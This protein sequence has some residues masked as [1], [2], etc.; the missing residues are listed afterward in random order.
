MKRVFSIDPGSNTGFV[1]VDFESTPGLDVN[2]ARIVG[3]GVV[4]PVGGRADNQAERDL[5]F[6]AKIAAQISEYKPGLV[7]LEEPSDAANYWGRS[8][9]GA[10]TVEQL[11]TGQAKPNKH[12]MARGTLFRLG[13]YYGLALSAVTVSAVG[14]ISSI[15]VLSYPVQGTK[16]RPGWMGHGTRRKNVLREMA[17]LWARLTGKTA[18][19]A[20]EQVSE[21]ELMALGVLNYH[22]SQ[23]NLTAPRGTRG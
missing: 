13:V 2:R 3:S 12:G 16:A 5:K 18:N 17:Y 1:V 21:H 14:T 8:D 20:A 4:R 6:V 22:A 10:A 7:V 23:L 19:Y 9:S 15:D 11:A